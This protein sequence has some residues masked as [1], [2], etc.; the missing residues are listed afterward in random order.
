VVE[1]GRLVNYTNRVPAWITGI[2][3]NPLAGMLGLLLL[4]TLAIS[5]WQF[6]R[7]RHQ[8]KNLKI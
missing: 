5:L 7:T 6:A 2:E 1:V 3:R 4:S 8:P